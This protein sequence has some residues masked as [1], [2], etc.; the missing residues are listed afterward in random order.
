[1]KKTI[2]SVLLFVFVSYL[3]AYNVRVGDTLRIEVFPENSTFTRTVRVANDGT[4]P[5][6]YAGNIQVVGKTTSEIQKI[7]ENHVKKYL[8]DFQLVV[9]VL[10]YAP[11]EVF[12]QGAINK[13]FDISFRPEVRLTTLISYL[14]LTKDLSIDFENIKYISG[15]NILTINLLPYFY[16]GY[17]ENDPVLKE[18]DIIYFPPKKYTSFIQITG[19]YTLT[20]DYEPGINLKYILAKLGPLNKEYAEIENAILYMDDKITTINLEDVVAGKVNYNLTQGAQLYIPKR[21]EKYAYIIGYVLAPGQKT[22]LSDEMMTLGMLIAKAGGIS[23]DAKRYVEA[24]VITDSKG[25]KTYSPDILEIANSV[26]IERGSIVEIRKYDEFFVYLQG[27][28]RVTGK[29]NLEPYEEKNLKK[30]FLKVGLTSE[31]IERE[32]IAVINGKEQI[33]IGEVLYGNKDFPLNK[34]DIVQ[35]LYEPFEVNVVGPFGSGRKLLGY[36]DPRTLPELVKSLGISQPEAIEK[37]V[38]LRN[39]EEQTFDISTLIYQN[40]NIPLQK[41]DTIVLVSSEANSVYLVGDVSAQIN[42]GYNEK[43]TL[44]RLLAK[45]GID[46]LRR[47]ESIE[48][49]GEKIEITSDNEISASSLVYIT[50][51]KPIRVVVSG[52]VTSTGR[53]EFNYTETADL[54]NLF[55][56]LGGLIVGPD[57]LYTSNEV[58][59]IRDGKL[60]KIFEAEKVARF[61]ENYELKD[62]D[63]IFVTYKEPNFVYIVSE[64]IPTGIVKFTSAEQF[65]LKTLIAKLGGLNPLV[66]EKI[67][68][69]SENG[70]TEVLAS[71]NVPL[72]SG[73]TVAF[74][75]DTDNFIYVIDQTGKPSMIYIENKNWTLYDILTKLNVNNTYRTVFLI[76][77]G[78]EQKIDVSDVKTT[79]GI[80]VKPGDV[81]K[82]FGDPQNVAYVLGEVNRPGIITLTERTTLVEALISSGGFTTKASASNIYVFKG[83]LESKDVR[84]YNLSGLMSGKNI[85]DNPVIEP[86]DVI[87]VPDNPFIT[88]LELLPTI[89]AII[90]NLTVL[91]MFQTNP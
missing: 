9:Y 14:G 50:L 41:K 62:G 45:A 31:E 3:F 25:P 18:R 79:L 40:P 28:A 70:T 91:F 76:R 33:D 32:G 43:L 80:I 23:E 27:A 59:L 52:F 54:K 87:Y 24:V 11:M 81:L 35:V 65:D 56:K 29:I 67:T 21:M 38:L 26:Q 46:D 16:N 13:T 20:L 7:L 84:T 71:E 85:K 47:I 83:G 30:L 44:Q 10:D 22:F 74:S 57:K 60:E 34:G 61:E 2:I 19:A 86:N 17:I 55:G 42:F 8:R 15:N 73:S 58:I 53:V 37:V 12:L 5:Y 63:V 49:N 82:V 90:S 39:G 88:A 69:I 1:M 51:K 72:K 75:K 68:I 66:S 89:S 36:K 78:K 48:I 4:I 6:P 77:N 64:D